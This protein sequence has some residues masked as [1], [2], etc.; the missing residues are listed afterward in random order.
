MADNK[1][2]FVLYCDLI[3]TIKKLPAEKAGLL[4]IHLLEYVNDQNPITDDILVEIAFEPI[5]HQLKR[6]LKKYEIKKE[7][8]S[9][10][11]KASA[12]AKK[13]KKEQESKSTESTYVEVR[14]TKTNER[15]KRSTESTVTVNVNDTVTVNVNDSNKDYQLSVDFWLKEFHPGW[16][17]S[18]MQGKALKS[19]LKK[20]DTFLKDSERKENDVF[21]FFKLVCLKIPD[22]FKDKDL[23]I[24][25]SKL[26]EIIT[27]I[28]NKNN[29]ITTSTQSIFRKPT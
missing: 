15:K 4:F 11:G 23:N 29:G 10:A 1:K 19:I 21:D 14:S 17:F 6:D 16:S 7:Q 22:W 8:W 9:E 12:E 25:D 27:Q 24:I 3:H 18:G 13:L 5:K 26:N 28:K 2:S 20:I